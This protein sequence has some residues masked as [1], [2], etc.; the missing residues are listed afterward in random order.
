MKE[1]KPDPSRL[2]AISE[3]RIEE[4]GKAVNVGHKYDGRR[5]ELTAG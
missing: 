3:Q 2:P 4:A 5:L 1:L